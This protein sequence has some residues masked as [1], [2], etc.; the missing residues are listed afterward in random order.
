MHHPRLL[1]A[2]AFTRFATSILLWATLVGISATAA[3]YAIYQSRDRGRSWVPSDTGIPRENRINTFGSLGDAVLVGT[4]AGIFLAGDKGRSWK[5]AAG[6]AAT[7]GRVI[8]IGTLQHSL[9]AGT[10]GNGMLTSLDEGKTWSQNSAFPSKK[11]RH[12]LNHDAKL[13]AG[14]DADG[15]FTSED[16]QRWKHLS[17]GFPAGGQAFALAALKDVLFVGLYSKGLYAWTDQQG[18]WQKAGP[19]SPLTLATAGNT[20]IVGHNPG[21]LYWSSNLGR[22]WLKATARANS[23]PAWPTS[24]EYRELSAEAPVWELA[25]DGH[26]VLSGASDGIYYSEDEGR[27]WIRA[28]VGLPKRCPGIAFF[29]GKDYLLAAIQILH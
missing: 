1:M 12:L 3:E 19:V 26:L 14:T 9:F 17:Q 2:P 13:Y 23:A 28:T 20:L 16:G 4:D 10:D 15:V 25:S 8:S 7:S 5:A 6:V 11:I 27:S 29:L 21:G 24:D 18:R 22:T